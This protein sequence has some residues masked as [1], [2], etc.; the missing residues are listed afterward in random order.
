MSVRA[1]RSSETIYNE[2]TIFSPTSPYVKVLV[3][4]WRQL[5][6]E[7][8]RLAQSADNLG[9][10][11]VPGLDEL[12]KK[13]EILVQSLNTV[14]R[15][16]AEVPA[17]S[18]N[19]ARAKLMVWR[20]TKLASSN[21]VNEVSPVDRLGLAATQEF[22]EVGSVLPCPLLDDYKELSNFSL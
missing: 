9:F 18:L 14:L 4:K 22:L 3:I 19:D 12:D 6:C 8:L 13:E 10:N 16:L 5:T 15:K 20:A 11:D 17:S 2:K 1:R 7:L 21:E